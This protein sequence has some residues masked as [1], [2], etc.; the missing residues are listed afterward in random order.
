MQWFSGL[1]QEHYGILG[2]DA[3]QST[4]ENLVEE[5]SGYM[6]INPTQRGNITAPEW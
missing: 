4:R 6:E 5:I 2:C 3:V 1:T